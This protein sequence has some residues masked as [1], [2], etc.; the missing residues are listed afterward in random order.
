MK[1]NTL[2]KI[3][4]LSVLMCLSALS[5]ANPVWIDVRSTGEYSADHIEGDM[6]IPYDHIVSETLKRIPDKNTDIKLY[7]RSG[8]RAG[9][10]VS[11]LKQAG[12]KNVSNTGGIVN[13]RT[14]RGL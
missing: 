2:R 5:Y 12:Y 1:I 4:W 13:T 9:I 11:A 3:I 10:A 14:M 6:N 7:C 8:R